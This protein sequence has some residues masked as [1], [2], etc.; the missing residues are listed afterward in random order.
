M[1]ELQGDVVL[2]RAVLDD[3]PV[4]STAVGVRAALLQPLAEVGDYDV[5]ALRDGRIRVRVTVTVVPDAAAPQLT[6]DL[7]ELEDQPS[8]AGRYVIRE[9]GIVSFAVGHGI[10]RYAVLVQRAS[11]AGTRTVLD[12][13]EHLPAGAMFAVTLVS[14]GGHRAANLAN[15]TELRIA[16]DAP[17]QGEPYSPARPTVV[18]AGDGGFEPAPVQMLVGQAIV[19]IADTP[20]RFV[21]EP[22]AS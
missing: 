11:A 18:R 12:T 9:G 17:Q 13:R 8:V 15:Q 10:R 22:P 20:A 16:V 7:A 3:A 6:L 21:V 5:M 4:D 19:L 2:D 1:F 14:T